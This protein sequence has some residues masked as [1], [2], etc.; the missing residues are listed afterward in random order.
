VVYESAPQEVIVG[1]PTL[2]TTDGAT[3][4]ETS[5]TR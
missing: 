1:E 4:I 3:V 2:A 5:Y